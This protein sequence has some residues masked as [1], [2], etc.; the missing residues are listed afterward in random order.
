MPL[1][2]ILIPAAL[3]FIIFSCGTT[4]REQ[5]ETQETEVAEAGRFLNNLSQYCGDTLKGTILTHQQQP[6]LEGSEIDFSFGKCT[7][8]EIRIGVHFPGEEQVH[9]ILT[10]INQELLLKHDV[11]D[12]LK[13]PGQNTMYGGFSE[14]DGTPFHQVFPVHNFGEAMWPGFENYAWEIFLNKQT[15]QLEYTERV[16]DIVI[17]HFQ[18]QL[19]G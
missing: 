11:R 14:S 9:I 5:E 15:G 13:A 10:L 6:G 17:K 12:T 2:S 18:A 19:P 16:E 3:L 8:N 1:R 7:E 4:P